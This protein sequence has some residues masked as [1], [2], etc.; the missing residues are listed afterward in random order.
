MTVNAP[1]ALMRGQDFFLPLLNRN[2]LALLE[3][4]SVSGVRIRPNL[5]LDAS[6]LGFSFS[7]NRYGLRGCDNATSPNLI[8]GTSFTMGFGVHNGQNWWELCDGEWF[9]IGLPV[10]VNRLRALHDTLY[11]GS[12]EQACV[13]F[14]PNF[15]QYARQYEEQAASGKPVHEFFGWVTDERMC[16]IL[17]SKIFKMRQY[18]AESGR[19]ISFE[20]DGIGHYMESEI[21]R[22]DFD[23][24]RGVVDRSLAHWRHVLSG[25]DKVHLVRARMKQELCPT[26]H[27]NDLLEAT[28]S[29]FD[30]GW[31]IFSEGLGGL[32]NCSVHEASCI[33]Y[34]H[35]YPSEGHW[36]AEG[37]AAFAQWFSAVVR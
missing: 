28:C 32:P 3:P 20:R 33:E 2:W 30:R 1:E 6:T 23:K 7:S 9:N 36:T 35:F 18:K 16:A 34:E 8:L 25:F 29:N 31:A 37:N 21:Y 12:R 22:F 17:Q 27:R 5:T 4:D 19:A 14:H 11:R 26:E 10:G 15:W 24:E 13:L